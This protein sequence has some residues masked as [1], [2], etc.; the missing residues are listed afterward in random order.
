MQEGEIMSTAS[1][2]A[3]VATRIAETLHAHGVRYAFGIPGND[4]LELIRACEAQ[5]ITF[6][7]A[8]SEPSAGFMADAAAPGDGQA[9][10]LHLR[11]RSRRCQRRHRHRRRADG[12]HPCHYSRR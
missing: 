1:G 8:K 4:V 9:C 10:G 12:A 7:L 3:T 11:A 2:K 6:M 5:G